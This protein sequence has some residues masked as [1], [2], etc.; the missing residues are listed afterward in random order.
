M[1]TSTGRLPED[2]R[3]EPTNGATERETLESFL[4]V[5]RATIVY[6][7]TG[8]SDDDAAKRLL[9]SETS[10]SGLIRHLADVERSW[11][12]DDLAGET[13][14]PTRWSDDDPDAEFRVTAGDR[15]ADIIADYERACDESRHVAANFHLN[16]RGV[17]NANVTLRW[18]LVH[19]IEETARHCGHIDI[20][21]EMLDG[22]TGE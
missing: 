12:R 11:F 1:P 8:L 4:E 15:L 5:N 10:V 18:I 21:R 7:A 6:K 9:P 19:M 22:A 17:H 13:S 2:T 3:P 16:D 20:L 14:V